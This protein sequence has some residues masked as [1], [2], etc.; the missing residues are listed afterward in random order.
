MEIKF[1]AKDKKKNIWHFGMLTY[2]NFNQGVELAIAIKTELGSIYI[3]RI[4]PKTIGQY[5]GL[6]DKNGVE[7][8]EGDIVAINKELLGC[9][10][11]K[12]DENCARYKKY[13]NGYEVSGIDKERMKACEVIGNIYDNPELLEK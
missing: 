10:V 12:Y 4:D 2:A 11:I 9:Y 8:Y 5:T 13:I 7:I 3:E 1:R 6:K